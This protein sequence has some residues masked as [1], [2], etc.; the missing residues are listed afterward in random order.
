MKNIYGNEPKTV[1]LTCEERMRN[2]T[3]VSVVD[4][5]IY[6]SSHNNDEEE[7]HLFM[8]QE[9]EDERHTFEND[10]VDHSHQ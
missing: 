5:G 9:L 2:A 6:V 1:E 3:H 4:E 8:A 10:H 7:T